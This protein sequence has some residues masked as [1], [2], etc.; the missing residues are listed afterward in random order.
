MHLNPQQEGRAALAARAA[1]P[2]LRVAAVL[3]VEGGIVLVRQAHRGIAYHLL[4]GGGVEPRESVEDAVR[5]EV[6]EETGLT[7]ELVAPLFITDTIDPAGTRHMVQLTFLAKVTGGDLI[8]APRDPAIVSVEVV[9]PE[10]LTTLDLRPPMA[11]ALLK[12][13]LR[14]FDVPA[15]YLGPLWINEPYTGNAARS[16][17][18]DREDRGFKFT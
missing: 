2:R 18:T 13:S 9:D 14:S 12:A 5:R 3:P 4:P 10:D 17:E 8:E 16:L 6:L 15:L 11:E 7:C 1:R